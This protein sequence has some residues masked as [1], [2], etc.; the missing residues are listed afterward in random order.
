MR[1]WPRFPGKSGR[2]LSENPSASSMALERV[3]ETCQ[4][5]IMPGYWRS[6]GAWDSLKVD[7]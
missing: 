6:R 7:L 4:G 3:P 2:E 1:R 5:G